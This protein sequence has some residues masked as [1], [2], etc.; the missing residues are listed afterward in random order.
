MRSGGPPAP[1][2][3]VL[4]EFW[5]RYAGHIE[6]DLLALGLNIA[7]WHQDTRDEHGRPVLSSRRLM[8]VLQHLA[9]DS[10]FKTHAVRR[11]RQTRSQRVHEETL[12]ELLRL[13]S[14]YEAVASQGKVAWNPA[15]FAWTDPVDE[16]EVARRRA[17]EAE[18]REHAEEDIFTDLGFT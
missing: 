16:L 8:V 3:P 11:G 15:D 17:E 7:D 12:N 18:E 10:A 13:R 6:S 5:K 1:K 14:S 2:V 9:D 4:V